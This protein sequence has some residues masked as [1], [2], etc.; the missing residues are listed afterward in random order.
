MAKHLTVKDI[1][2]LVTLIDVWEGKLTWEALCEESAKLIGSRP[3]RQTLNAHEKI[4]NAY[5]AQKARTKAGYT[6]SKRPASLSIAE[7][8]I[9]RLEGESSRLKED[10]D[11]CSSDL[12]D[13][14]TMPISLGC[15]RIS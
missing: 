2:A 1:D 8:R 6:P 9:R 3:T 11:G 7:Q 10:N 13:G 4:K 14:N 12:L 5:L 15:Q